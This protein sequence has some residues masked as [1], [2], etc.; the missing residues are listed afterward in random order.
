[1]HKNKNT[2]SKEQLPDE[3]IDQ[4]ITKLDEIEFVEKSDDKPKPMGNWF[5]KLFDPES[6]EKNEDISKMI[7]S[8]EDIWIKRSSGNWQKGKAIDMWNQHG[9]LYVIVGWYDPEKG[10]GRGVIKDAGLSLGK[11]V[12]AADFIKWQ[13]LAKKETK[14]KKARKRIKDLN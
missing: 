12:K 11:K 2:S 8:R 14:I 9:E 3:V 5:D 7:K 13:E 4:L 10:L 6:N 1:M